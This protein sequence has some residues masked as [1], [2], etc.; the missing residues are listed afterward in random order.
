MNELSEI[1]KFLYRN[2]EGYLV[3]VY[4]E[5]NIVYEYKLVKT[6]DEAYKVGIEMKEE[7][8]KK[9]PDRHFVVGVVAISWR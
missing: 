8:E 7:V 5:Y 6:Y 2:N 9:Y 1:I 4:D 3:A